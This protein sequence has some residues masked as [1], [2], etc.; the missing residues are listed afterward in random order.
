MRYFQKSIKL[1][2]DV[3]K[4]RSRQLSLQ[5]LS[6]SILLVSTEIMHD[7]EISYQKEVTKQSE[8]NLFYISCSLFVL[9]LRSWRKTKSQ[10]KII[11]NQKTDIENQKANLEESHKEITDSINYAKNIQDALMTPKSYMDEIL[12]ENFV[13]YLPKDVVSGDYY[14]AYKNSNDDIFFSV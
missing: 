2:V 7:K 10:N 14:W 3:Q 8:K 13:F 5:H 9:V 12:P 1:E 6:D 11:E 4:E